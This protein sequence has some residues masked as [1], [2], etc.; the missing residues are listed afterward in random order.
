MDATREWL[1]RGTSLGPAAP[2]ILSAQAVSQLKQ[3][4]SVPRPARQA[5]ARGKVTESIAILA[6]G[7]RQAWHARSPEE[8][9]C[10]GSEEAVV[11][12]AR[13]AASA[14]LGIAVYGAA[15][16]EDVDGVRW[17]TA[18]EWSSTC[19][20]DLVLGWRSALT[21][22]ALYGQRA[23]LWAHDVHVGQCEAE[24]L[25]AFDRVLTLSGFHER[26][27]RSA[28][29]VSLPA[30]LRVG[31]ALPPSAFATQDGP[32]DPHRLVY[33]SSPDRGLGRLLGMW[34]RVREQVP[35][36][37]LDVFYGIEVLA[38]LAK[39]SVNAAEELAGVKR[40]MQRD[41]PGVRW[42]G[43]VGQVELA[44]EMARAG[45]WAYPTTYPETFCIAL[46]RAEAAGLSIVATTSASL[47][48]V[49]SEPERLV[50]L[51]D[52]KWTD[53]VAEKFLDRLS[54]VLTDPPPDA[55]RAAI[56]QA[57]RRWTWR[58]VLDRILT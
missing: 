30:F 13:E 21:G 5:R 36:A 2:K 23:F 24:D 44:R 47:P 25:A 9:G 49:A 32:R 37:S 33:L 43:R 54:A 27:L 10:G 41:L 53:R 58:R 22:R 11:Y 4:M 20:A 34:S 18:D 26:M 12:L 29:P 52:D 31:N 16:S 42:R 46:P 45:V 51:D 1:Q 38:K 17:R 3:A 39:T 40:M 57:A 19:Q 7:S 55:E 15:R 8:E 28:Y 48:E 50:R 56:S 35:D 14:G 6:F